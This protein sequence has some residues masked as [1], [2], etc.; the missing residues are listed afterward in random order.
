MAK[1]PFLIWPDNRLRAV[2]EP[3][4]DITD[5]V[6]AIWDDMLETMY[7]MPGIGLAGPQIGVMQRVAV[8][9][10]SNDRKAPIR[11]ANPELL[12]VSEKF[13]DMDEGS[14]NLAHVSASVSRPRGITVS[15]VDHM[16]IRVRQDYVG[17][18]AR[19]IQHQIDHLNGKMYF[20]HLSAVK[21]RM[22]IAKSAKL[23]KR[24]A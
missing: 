9:D 1:R 17:M 20:D 13:V 22:L 5:C 12:H 23:A 8:V 7:A 3:V 15:Y 19:S 11:M 4:G 14:P 18:W 6:R 16:G 21:R 10:C 2:A 24:E